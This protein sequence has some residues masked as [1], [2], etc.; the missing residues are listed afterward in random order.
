M[1]QFRLDWDPNVQIQ[2]ILRNIGVWIPHLFA[3]ESRKIFISV[4]GM[5]QQMDFRFMLHNY[6]FRSSHRSI[7][8]VYLFF[9]FLEHTLVGV[10]LHLVRHA[11]VR[12]ALAFE[13]LTHQS[14]VWQTEHQ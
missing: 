7:C 10:G 3:L 1:S 6:E 9:T 4:D 11:M 12:P 13:I 8:I 2:T 14:V 5:N